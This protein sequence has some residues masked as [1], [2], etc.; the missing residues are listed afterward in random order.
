MKAKGLWSPPGAAVTQQAAS[1]S[2]LTKRLDT[3]GIRTCWK[4]D[5]VSVVSKRLAQSLCSA[6]T[7]SGSMKLLL[8]LHFSPA[9][10]RPTHLRE[11]AEESSALHFSLFFSYFVFYALLK[12]NRLM[13]A[14]AK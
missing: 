1:G 6:V 11:A 5:A 2:S 13:K 12:G 10:P 3:G 9:P 8:S 7:E 4:A 14:K